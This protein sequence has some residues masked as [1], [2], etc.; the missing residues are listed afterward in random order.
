MIPFYSSLHLPVRSPQ[1]R[2][3][4]FIFWFT[5]GCDYTFGFPTHH[6]LLPL[7]RLIWVPTHTA[8][9]A[10]VTHVYRFSSPL[11][12]Y[13][14]RFV[15]SRLRSL[16]PTHSFIATFYLFSSHT[17]T[18]IGWLLRLTLRYTVC[19]LFVTVDSPFTHTFD[20][21]HTHTTVL[22]PPRSFSSS[23]LTLHLLVPTPPPHGSFTTRSYP[24]PPP[25][26]HTTHH[27]VRC[28]V[29]YTTFITFCYVD[30][31]TFTL[32]VTTTCAYFVSGLRLLITFPDTTFLPRWLGS[33]LVPFCRLNTTF[34]FTRS[35][36]VCYVEFFT[37]TTHTTHV[38]FTRFTFCR[39]TYHI[40]VG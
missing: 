10:F 33:L 11:R 12:T 32:L 17:H 37:V 2:L 38:T 24:P 8:L 27:T 34:T 30:S 16:L 28:Y 26:P 23:W 1:L 21:P 7:P 14:Y 19:G 36:Y 4:R 35:V 6:T 18:H 3:P 39:F 40:A 22:L 9:F 31:F 25:P 5:T 13:T 20:S 29:Y 15:D